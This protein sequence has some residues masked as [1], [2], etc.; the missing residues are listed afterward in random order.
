[1]KMTWWGYLHTSGTLHAKRYFSDADLDDAYESPF[2]AQVVPTFEAEG[3][4]DALRIIAERVGKK[5][6]VSDAG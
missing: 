4:D 2:V 6:E 3:R 5:A 1:M